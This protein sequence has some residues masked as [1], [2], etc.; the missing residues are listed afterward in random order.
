MKEVIERCN[1]LVNKCNDKAITPD[2][3]DDIGYLLEEIE[4]LQ[5]GYCEL[6]E[7]CN[8]GECDCTHEE[9]NSM[10]EANIKLENKIERLNNDIK[11]LLKEN[12]NKEK[13]IKAQDNIIKEVR[14]YIGIDEKL[15]ELCINYDVNGIDILKI[16]DKV[17]K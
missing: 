13:V 16:L 10:C 4:R 14:E 1:W 12:E 2:V 3:K 11:E 6:K 5:K 9:Y 17:N 7:K 8:N 15:R